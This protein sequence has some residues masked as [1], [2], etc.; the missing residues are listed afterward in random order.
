MQS[1]VEGTRLQEPSD[2]D[3]SESTQ[4][5]TASQGLRSRPAHQAIA[6]SFEPRQDVGK[7][8][9]A[10]ALVAVDGA[11][12]TFQEAL[13]DPEWTTSMDTEM[14]GIERNETWK[15]VPR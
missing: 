4:A 1:S 9:I 14:E 2:S 13:N 8:G 12:E 15:L 10:A 6:A 7:A 5:V 3:D 11:P